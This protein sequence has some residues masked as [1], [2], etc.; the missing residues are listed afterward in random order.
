MKTLPRS[1]LALVLSVPGLSAQQDTA[2]STTAKR[3]VQITF[4]TPLGTNGTAAPRMVNRFS[5][6]ILAGVSAGTEGFEAGGLANIVLRELK[7]V[8]VAGL[9][10][11]VLG[12]VSGAQFSSCFNYN[13]GDYTGV[14]CSGMGNVS[15][16]TLAGGQFAGLFNYN[17]MGGRGIQVAAVS[18]VI[19]GDFKGTQASALSNTLLGDLEGAQISALVNVARK[20]KGVQ[21]GLVNIADSVDGVSIGL[22]N[23]IRHGM[24][25]A[26]I[27]AD[28]MFYLNLSYR[29][30]TPLF[31][32][33]FTAGLQPGSGDPL[34][35][36]GYGIGSSFPLAGKLRADLSASL[37]H[38]SPGR[39][40]WGTSELLRVYAG[41]EYRL[42]EKFAVSAGPVLNVYLSDELM[43]DYETV[44]RHLPPYTHADY[45]T[46]NDFNLKAWLGGRIA[47]RFL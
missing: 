7:G 14:A 12:G 27:S 25:Q 39:F 36:L 23:F 4:V 17:G 24:H 42:S 26:E 41:L 18:N 10:N 28:E 13:G 44:M 46:W 6:N 3:D 9:S 30:G 21:V 11:L 22:L 16:G 29:T 35:H 43:S 32:N 34:W 19:R 31:H 1:L 45:T 38:V 2:S 33:I 47:L 8:Q 15:L 40:Y 37:H 5:I 20:V